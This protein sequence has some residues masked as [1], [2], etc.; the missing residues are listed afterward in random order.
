MSTF[1]LII[2]LFLILV[3]LAVGQTKTIHVYVA[4]CDNENQ[5]IVP[6][7][8]QLGDGKDPKNNLYWGAAYG[9]KTFFISKSNNWQLLKS[10]NPKNPAILERLL[11]KH[12]SLD[13]YL[14]A[15]AYDGEQ[16]KVCIED[17]LKA[18]NGQSPVKIRLDSLKLGFGGSSDLQAYVGHDGLM[19]FA[20]DIDYNKVEKSKDV[21]I[22]AC[23]SRDYFSSEIR[24]SGAN[25]L[26]WTTH[27]MA[28]E[29]YTLEAAIEGWILNES[30][31]KIDERAAKAYNKYQKCGIRG[32]RNLFTTGYK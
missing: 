24:K 30:G 29:A 25:P 31:I 11:F 12:K 6:V 19:E 20:V 15:D 2:S 18:S 5:G 9:L 4:L 22:L 14:L 32:A 1:S 23:Y 10:I 26:L 17:F 16:I 27:L 8:D 13:F 7:P 21:I 3:S 28:P